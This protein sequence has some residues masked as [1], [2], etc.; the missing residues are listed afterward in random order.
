MIVQRLDSV[1]AE[2]PDMY[3]LGLTAADYI[4]NYTMDQR[5]SWEEVDALALCETA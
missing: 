1:A 3:G 2:V 4:C 5:E